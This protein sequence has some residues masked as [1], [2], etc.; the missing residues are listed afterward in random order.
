MRLRR[1]FLDD[2]DVL[3]KVISWRPYVGRHGLEWPTMRIRRRGCEQMSVAPVWDWARL[4]AP[5]THG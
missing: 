4:K 5:F 3:L 2:H 1:W